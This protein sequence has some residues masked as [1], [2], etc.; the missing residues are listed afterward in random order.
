L[1]T[2]QFFYQDNNNVFD[3]IIEE[4]VKACDRTKKE[5]ESNRRQKATS[6]N[7]DFPPLI[8]VSQPTATPR[9]PKRSFSARLKD[10]EIELGFHVKESETFFRLTGGK[11]LFKENGDYQSGHEIG[12]ISLVLHHISVQYGEIEHI[13]VKL[14]FKLIV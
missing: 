13:D 6:S 11:L 3:K 7:E 14:K 2:D 9:F 4:L 12:E 8:G 1:E 10:G 5:D